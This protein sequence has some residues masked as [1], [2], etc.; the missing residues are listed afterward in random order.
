[1]QIRIF[2]RRTFYSKSRA[3]SPHLTGSA[4]LFADAERYDNEE[5][6]HKSAVIL[7][8]DE[9]WTGD[10]K[11]QDTVLRMLVDKYKPLRTC[12]IQSADQKIKNALPR[13]T[14]LPVNLDGGDQT[15]L[16]LNAGSLLTSLKPSTGS[17]ATEPLLPSNPGHQPWH[18]TFQVPSH[19][20]KYAHIPGPSVP[21]KNP[22]TDPIDG[23]SRIQNKQA[24]HV[25][26]LTRARESTLYYRM[27][28]R[29]SGQGISN[30]L[31]LKGWTN[32]VEE[33]IEV[34][35]FFSFKFNSAE[36]IS[37]QKAR[38]AG[39]F[40]NVKGHGRPLAQSIEE[41]NPFIAREEYLLNRIV[42]RNGAAPPWVVVQ[43]GKNLS[44]TL[45]ST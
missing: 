29:K 32:L 39:L 12:S 41:H 22:S 42:Q 21:S 43:R 17:W 10:E 16:S 2:H 5:T 9:N 24:Q 34:G 1:M 6:P 31:T 45:V 20:I 27:G 11:I 19:S 25:G 4:K 44:P 7:E 38:Q 26:R 23:H 40:K 36:S 28:I 14:T 33:K 13:M 3:A 18:T 35:I 30:P 37:I 8:Q 15:D